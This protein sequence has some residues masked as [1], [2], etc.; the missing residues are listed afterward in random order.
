VTVG[1]STGNT[2]P[3]ISVYW[4][5]ANALWLQGRIDEAASILDDAVE[6]ARCSTSL[7]ASPGTS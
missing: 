2:D 4:T 6:A 5:L 7:M 1:R 3:F